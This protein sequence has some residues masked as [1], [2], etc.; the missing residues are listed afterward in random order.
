MS[1][2]PKPFHAY[3]KVGVEARV[4][5]ATPQQLIVLLFEGALSAVAMARLHMQNN[6]HAA[7][8]EAL[9]KA[10]MIIE[11]GLNA[12]LDNNVGG[13][14]ARDLSALYDYMAE[15]LVNANLQNSTKILDEVRRLLGELK[16][17]WETI[18]QPRTGSGEQPNEQRAARIYGKA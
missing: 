3:S 9:S 13:A 18:A 2:V 1:A 8:G 15:Q 11:E 10:I 12:S 14:L 4:L 5:S 17:A 16:T 7:K 6:N